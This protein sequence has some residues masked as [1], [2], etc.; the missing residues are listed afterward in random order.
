MMLRGSGRWP[1]VRRQ[2][3]V[4][5]LAAP[6]ILVGVQPVL[7]ELGDPHV[8]PMPRRSRSEGESGTRGSQLGW[9]LVAPGWCGAWEA[10]EDELASA[11]LGFPR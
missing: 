11:Q 10:G 2:L 7:V 4:V 8:F 1:G 6:G 9:R 5:A 3:S